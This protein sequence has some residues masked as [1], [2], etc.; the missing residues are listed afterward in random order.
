ME[1]VIYIINKQETTKYILF[2]GATTL[3]NWCVYALTVEVAGLSI[4][5][6]NTVS[7]AVA[8]L[9]AFITNKIWVFT[10]RSWKRSILLLEVVSFFG[11]RIVTS[12]I[13]IGG[14]PL[15]I[16][17]GLDQPLFGIKGFT[18]KAAVGIIVIVLNYILSKYFVFRQQKE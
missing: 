12:I 4:I 9:F 17:L 11:A 5:F 6:G 8:V 18:A 13:E 16:S 2:G 7:W 15:L 10:S 1:R 14:V 3:V